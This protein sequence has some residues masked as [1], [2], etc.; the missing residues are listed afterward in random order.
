[1]LQKLGMEFTIARGGREGVEKFRTE[2]GRFDVVLMDMTM[3]EMSGPEAA[4]QMLNLK[5]DAKIL[6]MSGYN[7]EHLD[8]Q[9]KGINVIGFMP[10]PFA[11]ENL[12]RSLHTAF[13]GNGNGT[14][15]NQSTGNA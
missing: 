5:S 9:I 14:S 11:G 2:D 10:K 15:A 3:P 13:N 6:M 7:S 8:E 12:C 1:M 4:R